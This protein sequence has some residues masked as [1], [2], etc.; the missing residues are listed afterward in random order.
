MKWKKKK[1]TIVEWCREKSVIFFATKVF[2]A[3][4]LY[5][6]SWILCCH[7]PN[8]SINSCISF[9]VQWY[10][11]MIIII[12]SI[13]HCLSC[14]GKQLVH[15]TVK[16]RRSWIKMKL[17]WNLNKTHVTVRGFSQSYA[18]TV[19]CFDDFFNIPTTS[20]VNTFRGLSTSTKIIIRFSNLPA[21]VFVY[22]LV[23]FTKWRYMVE[24]S[25][26]CFTTRFHQGFCL[27]ILKLWFAFD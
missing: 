25:I 20:L 26:S 5:K 11:L 24:V 4:T 9:R 7:R 15:L 14:N 3:N 22:T 16:I 13:T 12:I 10:C 27:V 8:G 21:R 17:S 6:Q 23:W 1:I 2:F 19:N 18:I